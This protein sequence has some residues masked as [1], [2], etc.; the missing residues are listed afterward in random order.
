[1]ADLT[2]FIKLKL[3]YDNCFEGQRRRGTPG[4][5]R[6]PMWRAY[7]GVAA[8]AGDRGDEG[9]REQGGGGNGMEPGS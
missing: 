8:G 3:R 2:A 4:G 9:A 6:P 7:W 5:R 1:M